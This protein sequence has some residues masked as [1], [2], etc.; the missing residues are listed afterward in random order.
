MTCYAG[1]RGAMPPR[2]CAAH[3]TPDIALKAANIMKLGTRGLLFHF[4]T[5]G[6]FR[7]RHATPAMRIGMGQHIDMMPY[8]RLPPTLTARVEDDSGA[9]TQ[10]RT[11]GQ[12]AA[13]LLLAMSAS[14]AY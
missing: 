4:Q 8:G 7:L 2:Y 13:S 11:T 9:P 5:A 3:I 6:A 1:S 14:R 12:E 10:K